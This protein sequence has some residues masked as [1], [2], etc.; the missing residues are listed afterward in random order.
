MSSRNSTSG[1]EESVT[2]RTNSSQLSL[3]R[4]C[5]ISVGTTGT[6]GKEPVSHSISGT[7]SAMTRASGPSARSMRVLQASKTA[8]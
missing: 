3:T 8:P 5:A 7:K 6:G 1:G 2:A 4:L